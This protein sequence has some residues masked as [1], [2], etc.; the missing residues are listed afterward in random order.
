MATF[1]D[2]KDTDLRLADAYGKHPVKGVLVKHTEEF[3]GTGKKIVKLKYALGRR[4]PWNRVVKLYYG[5][6]EIDAA[7]YRFHRGLSTDAPDDLFPGDDAVPGVPYIS[8]QLPP[9]MADDNDPDKVEGVYETL[10]VHNY[11]A[12]GVI[13][14]SNGNALPAGANPED[15]LFYS[16]S[17]ALE[18]A[19]LIKHAGCGR[20][21]VVT[22]DAAGNSLTA[23]AHGLT[24][25]WAIRFVT[26]G[27][28]PGGLVADK[29]YFVR[30]ATANTLQVSATYGGAVLDLTDVGAGAIFAVAFQP[31]IVWADLLHKR[32]YD[33]FLLSWNDGT[34]TRNIP[35]F[36]SHVFFPTPYRLSDAGNLICEITCADWQ[37]AN[38][39][40]RFMTPEPRTPVFT[41]DRTKI[42]DGTFKTR[43]VDRRQ[44]PNRVT[45]D[46]RDLDTPLLQQAG[47]DGAAKPVVINRKALQDA[48]G[49]VIKNHAINGGGM[50]RA[51]A[52]RVGNFWARE[53]IDLDQEAE[54]DG[55]PDAYL[56]LPADVILTTYDTPDWDG[57]KFKVIT[58]RE[59]DHSK[60]GYPMLLRLYSENS[61][62]DTDQG[63]LTRPLPAARLNPFTAPPA[64]ASL[65]T[66]YSSKTLPSGDAVAV[67]TGQA[68]FQPFA[69]PQFGRVWLKKHSDPDS[70]WALYPLPSFVPEPST[71]TAPFE[72]VGVDP[73]Q[74][75]VKVVTYSQAGVSADFAT[76]PTSTVTIQIKPA[77]LKLA[78][79]PLVRSAD[80]GLGFIAGWIPDPTAQGLALGMTLYR[81][82]QLGQGYQPIATFTKKATG[83][84]S[85]T[86]MAAVSDVSVFDSASTIRV[87]FQNGLPATVTRDDALGGKNK[88]L[89][90]SV[91]GVESLH[92]TTATLVSGSTFDLS[93]FWRGFDGT[94]WV[95][96]L[97]HPSGATVLV[98]DDAV[99]FV[100]FDE[101][102]IGRALLLKPVAFGA[103]LASVA[104]VT[105][106]PL[107]NSQR[108]LAVGHLAV[109]KASTAPGS[110][111]DLYP[112]W[113]PRTNL[114]I[115]GDTYY[116]EIVNA[117]ATAPVRRVR[118]V[119]AEPAPAV[120]FGSGGSAAS[121][122]TLLN[123]TSVYG[124]GYTQ[125]QLVESYGWV[126]VSIK[127]TN[128]GT[129]IFGLVNA[130]QAAQLALVG[131][132]EI[133]V[134]AVSVVGGGQIQVYERGALVKQATNTFDL[135]T[136][137]R[138][139]IVCSGNQ[140][141]VYY[142]DVSRDVPFYRSSLNGEFLNFPLRAWFQ[143]APGDHFNDIMVSTTETG[144][145]YPVSDQK[146][147]YGINTLD[148]PPGQVKMRVRQWSQIRGV[149]YGFPV[150]AII[151]TTTN[152]P[153]VTF[154]TFTY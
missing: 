71:L 146:L 95:A 130:R 144:F 118:A 135:A 36:E 6:F 124:W 107:G 53:L 15:Y 19:D 44:K 18:L 29:D 137:P 40:L 113:V 128:N 100:P 79:G 49:G 70:A 101:D 114:N 48:E 143:L 11:D 138:I 66:S 99:Q 115:I 64:V 150:D 25:N 17:P 56:A 127:F 89:I 78:E 67:I 134:R 43:P 65:T 3:D 13:V 98:L 74:Y 16:A 109:R 37:R 59:N 76:H 83:G 8:V 117:A 9:G 151:D 1:N 30:N 21:V 123:S 55:P 51:Q 136:T 116:V 4:G 12:T 75:D 47:T 131:T 105:F 10:C 68:T 69:A 119:E 85:T 72:L 33:A 60:L 20:R 84:V 50:L 122:N 148:P 141:L 42:G 147:D 103:L 80:S 93:G 110:G 32:D 82:R 154:T 129:S 96:A 46:Y 142:L 39:R 104:P 23:T 126:E 106:T 88:I 139:R 2:L 63:P 52:E 133:D 5:G 28:L 97:G 34:T 152:P 62:S 73:D 57:V 41:C 61:Y 77:L 81:D 58:K 111:G 31:R 108:P 132:L 14:D 120:L 24:N 35:R 121:G 140:I 153:T 149:G 22:P 92:Y 38:G 102:D 86:A 145:S 27:T 26:Q 54:Y 91:N 87:N 7:N 125:Q 94:E 90:A 112:V 45:V